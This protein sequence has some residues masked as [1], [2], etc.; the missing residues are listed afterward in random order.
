MPILKIKLED[1]FFDPKV[2]NYCVNPNFK[3]PN[4]GHSWACPPETPYLEE[5]VANYQKFFL[6]YVK[7]NLREYYKEEK[8]KNPKKS[9]ESI[10][11]AFFMKNF[12]RDNLEHEIVNFIEQIQN[13]Y[14]EKLILWDGFCRVCYNKRDKGC[15]YDSG[16]PCRYPNKKRYSMEAVGID[17]TKTVKNLNFDIEWPPNDF[18][19][20][21][22]LI[23][24]K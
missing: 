12:L 4:F 11:N 24:I 20:R 1:I 15:N 18:I 6:V 22:G 23:C 19:Y 7:F 2:Q 9:E 16:N 13:P 21:F 10:K 17:V 5:E 14:R 3:C 8:I